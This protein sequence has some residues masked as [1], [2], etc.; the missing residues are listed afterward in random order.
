MVGVG[1]SNQP[2]TVEKKPCPNEVILPPTEAI[3]GEKT[4]PKERRIATTRAAQIHLFWKTFC[5][6]GW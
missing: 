1:R 4:N 6:V 2:P 5:Q 3:C